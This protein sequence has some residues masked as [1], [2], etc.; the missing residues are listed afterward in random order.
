[1]ENVGIYSKDKS[2]LYTTYRNQKAEINC[3]PIYGLN[4]KKKM[5]IAL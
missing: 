3:S 1:M 5:C 4:T 2:L